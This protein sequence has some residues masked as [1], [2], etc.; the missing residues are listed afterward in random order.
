[1]HYFR[2]VSLLLV[3]CALAGCSRN[4]SSPPPATQ[5]A[6]KVA[7]ISLG[8]AIAA[9]KTVAA[10]T[11]SF[12]PADT[13]YLSV[14][15]EG[16]AASARLSARWTYE[17]GQVVSESTQSIAPSGPAVTEFHASKPD[18]WPEGSY[19]VEVSLNGAPAG[20]KEFRVSQG[21]L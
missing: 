3:A 16:S 4:E 14:K 10:Q 5:G 7:S 12:R 18:G 21:A 2:S 1:M 17:D 15:T 9:D 20:R 11:D 6:V 19:K 13:F 8:R